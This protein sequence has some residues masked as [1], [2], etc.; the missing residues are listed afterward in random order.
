MLILAKV[1]KWTALA[2]I[3]KG[4]TINN[5]NEELLGSLRRLRASGKQVVSIAAQFLAFNSSVSEL[6][7]ARAAQLIRFS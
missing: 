2:G 7:A 5:S 4:R 1:A 6:W 3:L